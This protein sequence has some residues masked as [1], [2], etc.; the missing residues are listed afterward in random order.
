[1]PLEERLYRHRCVEAWSMAVP[2]TGFPLAKLVELAQAARSAKYVRMETFM[3]PTSRRA[4]G[5]AGI[6][7]PISKG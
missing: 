5:R 2:W 4:S 3:D 7:G 6:R 1:M